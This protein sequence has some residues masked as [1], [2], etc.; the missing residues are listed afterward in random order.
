MTRA[1][2][3]LGGS[4]RD[5]VICDLWNAFIIITFK[6]III[7][8]TIIFIITTVKIIIFI[9][10]NFVI[11]CNWSRKNPSMTNAS[12][13]LKTGETIKKLSNIIILYL[14]KAP[15]YK[16]SSWGRRM[17]LMDVDSQYQECSWEW[18]G[19]CPL[20]WRC[21]FHTLVVR[22]ATNNSVHHDTC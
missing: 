2:P 6:I 12:H 21:F 9:T 5:L 8:N 18:V 3:T 19:G 16:K 4:A 17:A 13:N 14:T 22:M 15:K 11:G 1:D 10:I 20:I 7:I